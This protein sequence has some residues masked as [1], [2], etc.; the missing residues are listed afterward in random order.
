M[1]WKEWKSKE[2]T[3]FNYTAVVT[4][5]SDF[6]KKFKIKITNAFYW[7]P[8]STNPN[9]LNL[10]LPWLSAVSSFSIRMYCKC[11]TAIKHRFN[12]QDSDSGTTRD[13]YLWV[14]PEIV[15]HCECCLYHLGHIQM[16]TGKGLFFD[17]TIQ[18]QAADG[19]IFDMET[20]LSQ[21]VW[22]PCPLMTE[23]T[24][25]YLGGHLIAVDLCSPS[26]NSCSVQQWTNK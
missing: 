11:W 26:Q 22:P 18:N 23:W 8:K 4:I 19:L 25:D 21:T 6:G 24:P 17:W 3:S 12:E 1:I 15:K 9:G 2:Q 16:P 5:R 7:N 10:T 14:G 13:L 20:E